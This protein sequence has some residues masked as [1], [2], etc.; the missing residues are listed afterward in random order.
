MSFK[1]QRKGVHSAVPDSWGDN[2]KNQ[3]PYPLSFTITMK[4]AKLV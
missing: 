1:S 4:K 3:V 2:R